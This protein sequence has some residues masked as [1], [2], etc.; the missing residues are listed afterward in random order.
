[1]PL[2]DFYIMVDWSGAAQRRGRRPI[3]SLHK[4][5]N[6]PQLAGATPRQAAQKHDSEAA[7]EAIEEEKRLVRC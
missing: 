2:F 3:A 6:D 4:L 7:Q 1:M 5:R